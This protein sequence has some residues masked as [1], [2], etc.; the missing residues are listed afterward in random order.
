MSIGRIR[1][2]AIA[3]A[4][5]TAVSGILIPTTITSPALA[6]SNMVTDQTPE[7][8]GV[9]YATQTR[10][11]NG[12]DQSVAVVTA[13]AASTINP[14]INTALPEGYY[15]TFNLL[16]GTDTQMGW[17]SST[18][19]NTITFNVPAGTEAGTSRIFEF[20]V[21][22][23][24]SGGNEVVGKIT[25]RVYV[26]PPANP[27]SETTTAN[28]VTQEVTS[29][30]TTRFSLK[31]AVSPAENIQYFKK[32]TGVS[33]WTID[34]SKDGT[35]AATPANTMVGNTAKATYRVVY[36]DGSWDEATI[37][38]TVAAPANGGIAAQVSAPV[39]DDKTVQAGQ[40]VSIEPKEGTVNFDQVRTSYFNSDLPEGWTVSPA[41]PQGSTNGVFN[42]STPSS[43][44]GSG[45]IFTVKYVFTDGTTKDT[46]AKISVTPDPS[47]PSDMA[48]NAPGYTVPKLYAGE[49][50]TI[51]QTG[52]TTLPD[53]TTFT[54]SNPPASGNWNYSID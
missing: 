2:I 1:S 44:T 12:E 18:K 36:T 17:T 32:I 15:I 31:D 35:V 43:E 39:Y 48:N 45:Y 10:K 19:D 47:G 49:T 13:G 7:W 6:Q 26:D 28:D 5:S 24:V 37:N 22:K 4:L 51:T 46:T 30:G 50:A 33:T 11:V 41:R 14:T 40:S 34:I 54:M 42:L 29:S 25:T 9:T 20:A 38:F 16:D 27:L 53:G 21:R 3:S 52:D 23:P 8:N